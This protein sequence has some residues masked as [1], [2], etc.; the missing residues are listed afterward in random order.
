VAPLARLAEVLAKVAAA[1]FAVDDGSTGRGGL[2][3]GDVPRQHEK[4][5]A[6]K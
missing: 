3:D 6:R 1:S 4:K 2:E 5:P